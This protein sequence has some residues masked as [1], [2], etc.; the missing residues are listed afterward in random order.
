MQRPS[1]RNCPAERLAQTAHFPSAGGGDLQAGTF[2]DFLKVLD[3]LAK[4]IDLLVF[5][6]DGSSRLLGCVVN[7][8][9]QL[10]EEPGKLFLHL[11]KE[12]VFSLRRLV[13]GVQLAG[14]LLDRCLHC[15]QGDFRTIVIQ[16]ELLSLA[17]YAIQRAGFSLLGLRLLE[18]ALLN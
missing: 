14:H 15:L 18:P 17:R 3:A 2:D 13:Q 8:L 4:T 7:H 1:S 6:L 9:P 12:V 16:D 10:I 5:L 11:V